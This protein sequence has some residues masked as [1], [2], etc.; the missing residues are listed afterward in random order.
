MKSREQIQQ[1][2][3]QKAQQRGISAN[4]AVVYILGLRQITMFIMRIEGFLVVAMGI[5]IWLIF[6]FM[7]S[8]KKWIIAIVL[9]LLIALLIKA[10]LSQNKKHMI[11]E[12]ALK[13][14]YNVS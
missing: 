5:A 6:T 11:R 10:M 4:D 3:I 7:Q 14:F 9:I 8:A 1:E 2:A 12:A 13:Q